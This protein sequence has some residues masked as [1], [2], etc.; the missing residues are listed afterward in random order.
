MKKLFLPISTLTFVLVIA[1]IL[2]YQTGTPENGTIFIYSE[3]IHV[4]TVVLLFILGIYFA[5]QRIISREKGLPED[6]ELSKRITQKAAAISFYISLFIWLVLLYILNNTTIDISVLFSYGF[7]GMSLAFV[8][9]WF[10]L[11]HVGIQND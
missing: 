11:N 10:L 8:L 2:I 6:D 9:S 4:G 7:I 5:V 1:G 3:I